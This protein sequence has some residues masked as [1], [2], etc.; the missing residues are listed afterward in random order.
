MPEINV[1]HDDYDNIFQLQEQSDWS[2]GPDTIIGG[3]GSDTVSYAAFTAGIRIDLSGDR[4]AYLVADDTETTNTDGIE[5]ITGGE[6]NDEITGDAE[7]NVLAGGPGNDT[8]TGKEGQDRYV[9]TSSWGEDIVVEDDSG[10]WNKFDAGFVDTLDFTGV[11]EALT[12]TVQDG[13][14]INATD[15]THTVEGG[16]GFIERIAG[17]KTSDTYTQIDMEITA[18]DKETMLGTDTTDG[19]LDYLQDWAA[20]LGG[21]VDEF[22]DTTLFGAI[23]AEGWLAPLLFD[24]METLIREISVYLDD[25]NAPWSTGD[26]SDNGDGTVDNMF[27]VEGITVSPTTYQKEFRATL[28]LG[29]LSLTKTIDL[30]EEISNVLGE[31]A[32][33]ATTA[34][35]DLTTDA[36]FDFSFGLEDDGDFYLADPALSLLNLTAG[37]TDINLG[38]DLGILGAGVSGGTL[39]YNFGVGFETTGHFVLTEDSDETFNYDDMS[40]QIVSSGDFIIDLPLSIDLAGLDF[41]LPSLE[42]GFVFGD[43]LFGGLTLDGLTT[44][45]MAYLNLS[46]VN[47]DVEDLF[48]IKKISLDD[49]VNVLNQT[50]DNIFDPDGLWF[51]AIPGVEL[52]L[53]DLTGGIGSSIVNAVDSLANLSLNEIE[54]YLDQQIAIPG[55]PAELGPDETG[56]YLNPD[57]SLA[58]NDGELFFGFT[59]DAGFN[60]E[61]DFGFDLD[62]FAGSAGGFFGAGGL[63]TVTGG[64]TLF[65]EVFAILEMGMGIDLTVDLVNPDDSLE[66]YITDSSGIEAGISLIGNDLNFVAAINTGLDIAP[67][68]GLHIKDGAAAAGAS[69]GIRLPEGDEEGHLPVDAVLDVTMAARGEFA[70]ALP[71]FLTASVTGTAEAHLGAAMAITGI[72]FLEAGTDLHY[73]QEISWSSDRPVGEKLIIGD[74]FVSLAGVYLEMGAFMTNL[75]GPV[76]DQV[77]KITQPMQPIA[78]LWNGPLPVIGDLGGPETVGD[79]VELVAGATDPRIDKMAKFFDAIVTIVEVV[80][81]FAGIDPNGRIFFGDFIL[82]SPGEK[83]DNEPGYDTTTPDRAG[84]ANYNPM[85]S[86]SGV[87]G[88]SKSFYSKNIKKE[89]GQLEF[90]IITDPTQIF[91][92]LT[93]RSADL[94]RYELP[95]T[96]ISIEYGASF[97]IFSG[98]NAVIGGS[99]E[100]GFQLGF[101]YDSSGL[102]QYITELKTNDYNLLVVDPTVVFDGFFLNDHVGAENNQA[103]AAIPASDGNVDYPEAWLQARLE[104]GLALGIGGLVEAG[105][106]G[107]FTGTVMFDLAEPHLDDFAPTH[108]MTE[109]VVEKDGKVTFRELEERFNNYSACCGP[110]CMIETSGTLAA[111]LSAFLWVGVKIFGA[112]ITLF[113][114]SF[115]LFEITLASFNHTCE[116]K[117]APDPASL[118]AEP[119]AI[120][121][122]EGDGPFPTNGNGGTLVLHMGSEA[123]K[124]GSNGSDDTDPNRDTSFIVE[125]V[126]EEDDLGNVIEENGFVRVTYNDAFMEEFPREDVGRIMAVGGSGNDKIVIKKP[127]DEGVDFAPEVAFIGGGGDDYTW[128]QTA[129]IAVLEGGDGD[130]VLIGGSDDDMIIGGDGND[131]IDGGGGNDILLGGGA[132]QIQGGF[133]NDYLYGDGVRFDEGSGALIVAPALTGNAATAAAEQG[134]DKLVG[135]GGDDV[136]IGFGGSD[137]LIG[138]GMTTKKAAR[139]GGVEGVDY[140]IVALPT[141]DPNIDSER[142]ETFGNDYLFGG[143]GDDRLTGYAGNDFLHGEDGDDSLNAGRGDDVVGV[144]QYQQSDFSGEL[145]AVWT[146]YLAAVNGEIDEDGPDTIRWTSG[147]GADQ[148][149]AGEDDDLLELTGAG[150]GDEW[151]FEPGASQLDVRMT[152]DGLQTNL[153]SVEKVVLNAGAGADTVTI[154]DIRTTTVDEFDIRLGGVTETLGT[155]NLLEAENRSVII[156]PNGSAEVVVEEAATDEEIKQAMIDYYG[157][158]EADDIT[159]NDDDTITVLGKGD[160]IVARPQQPAGPVRVFT[161]DAAAD[162]VVLLGSDATRDAFTINSIAS[163]LE[164]EKGNPIEQHSWRVSQDA[165]IMLFTIRQAG[166]AN[167]DELIIRTGDR[168]DLIDASGVSGPGADTMALTA[169]T[170]DG[171][172]ELRGTAFDDTLRGGSGDDLYTGGAGVD[173]FED[174]AGRNVLEEQRN[175]DFELTDGYLIVG[176]FSENQNSPFA[177]DFL[178]AS[179]EAYEPYPDQTRWIEVEGTNYYGWSNE[180]EFETLDNVRFV[181]FRLS[182]EDQYFSTADMWTHRQDIFYIHHFNAEA[183]L[184]GEGEAD[185][186]VIE[187]ATSLEA[188]ITEQD[189]GGVGHG[190]VPGSTIGNDT[191]VVIGTENEDEFGFNADS[192]NANP[193]DGEVTFGNAKLEYNGPEHLLVHGLGGDDNFIMDDNGVALLIFGGAGED[194]FQ[195]GQVLEEAFTDDI[196]AILYAAEMSSGVSLVSYFYGGTGNDYMEVN[197]NL[198]E[199]FLYGEDDNDRFVIN[200]HLEVDKTANN[201]GGVGNNQI[202]YVQNATVNING[203]EGIDTVVINGTPIDDTFIVAVVDGKQV[204]YGAGLQVGEMTDV[205]LLEVNGAAGNDSIYVFGTVDGMDLVINGGFGDDTIYAGGNSASVYV[206]PP[207]YTY[208]PPSYIVDPEPFQD[209]WLLEE[210]NPWPYLTSISIP[211]YEYSYHNPNIFLWPYEFGTRWHSGSNAWY[212]DWIDRY[213]GVPVSRVDTLITNSKSSMEAEFLSRRAPKQYQQYM[214]DYINDGSPEGTIHIDFD[215]WYSYYF[216]QIWSIG[217]G[218]RQL[219][220]AI[221]TVFGRGGYSSFGNTAWVWVDPAPYMQPIPNIVDPAPYVVVPEPVTVDPA[222]FLFT[223]GPSHTLSAFGGSFVVDGGEGEND[224]IVINS[225]DDTGDGWIGLTG[226]GPVNVD[227]LQGL[228]Y[229]DAD[230]NV[231]SITEGGDYTV[232]NGILTFTPDVKESTVGRVT[233]T[234]DGVLNKEGNPKEFIKFFR[235][236][237]RTILTGRNMQDGVSIEFGNA[238]ILNIE[239]SD[240]DDVFTV[241]STPAGSTT[242]VNA[243]DGNDTLHIESTGGI[244][245]IEG[246]GG[247]DAIFT[248]FNGTNPADAA[249]GSLVNISDRLIIRSGEGSDS[250][251]TSDAGRNEA[252]II[253]G[254][255]ETVEYIETV[256]DTTSKKDTPVAA[257]DSYGAMAGLE[258]QSLDVRS[259]FAYQFVKPGS[260]AEDYNEFI[261]NKLDQLSYKLYIKQGDQWIELNDNDGL[262]L[263][264]DNNKSWLIS[265]VPLFDVFD[266]GSNT[267]KVEATLAAQTESY[268]FDLYIARTGGM[269]G[270]SLGTIDVTG[271]AAFDV[272][273][274]GNVPRYRLYQKVGVSWVELDETSGISADKFE[275]LITGT[276]L[277]SDVGENLY[278]LEMYWRDGTDKSVDYAFG[279]DIRTA[280]VQTGEEMTPIDLRSAFGDSLDDWNEITYHLEGLPVGSGLKV[281]DGSTKASNKGLIIGNPTPMDVTGTLGRTIKLVA[282]SDTN[283]REERSFTLIVEEDT[284]MI[285]YKIGEIDL[286]TAVEND[287]GSLDG[288]SYA[289]SG[290]DGS[291]LT[292]N[293]QSGI[294]SGMPT[295]SG[296]YAIAVTAQKGAQIQTYNFSIDVEPLTSYVDNRI[297]AVDLKELF[298]GE[299]A[300][301]KNVIYTADG[302]NGTG[303]ILDPDTWRIVG[304]PKQVGIQNWTI[305]ATDVEKTLEK[306]LV[307][308]VEADLPDEPVDPIAVPRT[309][310]AILRQAR[311]TSFDSSTHISYAGGAFALN[312]SEATVNQNDVVAV[313]NNDYRLRTI[314][315]QTTTEQTRNTLIQTGVPGELIEY[316]GIENLTIETGQHQD[317][318]DIISTLLGL[319]INLFTHSGADEINIKTTEI[320]I[321][322]NAGDSNDIVNIGSR[323]PESNGTV[324]QIN[325]LVTVDGGGGSDMLN[326]DETGESGN[327]TGSLTSQT[328]TG[329]GMAEGVRYQAFAT[330]NIELGSG[331]DTF[332]VVST[333]SGTSNIYGNSNSD[334]IYVHST[335]GTTLI[336]GGG[337]SDQIEVGNTANLLNDIS[338]TLIISGTGGNDIVI[339]NDSGESQP[340]S[341]ILSGHIL[342]GFGIGNEINVN[343][344]E[345]LNILLGSNNDVLTVQNTYPGETDI[346]TGSGNDEIVIN[347][348]GGPTTIKGGSGN[349]Q[350]TTN[351]LGPVTSQ[352]IGSVLDTLTLD[353]QTGSDNYVINLSGSS[354]YEINIEDNGG[355]T[356]E[357]TM[358]LNATNQDDTLLFRE[359]FVALLNDNQGDDQA[360]DAVERINYD[361]QESDANVN[362]GIETLIVN[363]LGGDDYL[364][365]DDNSAVTELYGGGNDWFQIGQLFETPRDANAGVEPRDQYKENDLI[366][367]TTDGQ[368]SQWL[369]NGIS[370]E[371]TINGGSDDDIFSVYHNI[372]ELNLSG[373]DGDDR[374]VVRSFVLKDTSNTDSQQQMV[375]IKAGSGDNTIAYAAKAPV[376]ISGGSGFDSI[377]VTGTFEAD[378][379]VITAN[380]IYGAGRI[381]RYAGVEQIEVDGLE[382][383]DS[384]YVRSTRENLVTQVIGGLGNDTIAVLGEIDNPIDIGLVSGAELA[385]SNL[386][387]ITIVNE[388]FAA[389][390]AYEDVL[391]ELAGPLVV[392]GGIGQLGSFVPDTP[393]MLL[394]EKDGDKQGGIII[395]ETPEIGNDTESVDT[396]LVNNDD[397]ENDDNGLLSETQLSGLGLPEDL[398]LGLEDGREFTFDGGISYTE[399]EEMEIDLGGGNDQFRINSTFTGNTLINVGGGSDLIDIQTIAGSTTVNTGSE[400]DQIFVGQDNT[401]SRDLDGISAGLTF[402]LGSGE[403]TLSVINIADTNDHT[404]DITSNTLSW[405][406]IAVEGIT[407]SNAEL[408]NIDLGTG[409]NVFNILST[410]SGNTNISSLSGSETFNVQTVSGETVITSGSGQDVFNIGTL[411]PA[412]G[413]TLDLIGAALAVDA[414]SDADIINLDDSGDE[415]DNAGTLI[416][417]SLTGFDMAGKIDYANFEMLNF[418]SGSG[419]DTLTIESTHTGETHVE[420][421]L[422]DDEVLVGAS[423]GLLDPITGLLTVTDSEG[424]DRITM[425]DAGDTDFNFGDLTANTLSGLGLADVIQYSGYETT[426]LL[427][428]TNNDTLN[429]TSIHEGTTRIETG[430]GIDD[431]HVGNLMPEAGGTLN[432]IMGL[433]Q[434]IGGEDG[435][436]L[437]IDH[438][439]EATPQAARLTEDRLTGL[440]LP[441]AIEYEKLSQLH[442]G[443]GAGDDTFNVQGTSAHT[444]LR[445]NDGNDRLFISSLADYGT[446]DPPPA[447]LTGDLNAINGPLELN[448]GKGSHR[449]MVSDS[450]AITGDA[451]A[452]MTRETPTFMTES[453][454]VL[455]GLSSGMIGYITDA[456]EGDFA[457]G[458]HVWLSQGDDELAINATHRREGVHTITTVRTNSGNDAINIAIDENLDDTL[459][460]HG[461]TGDDLLDGS[462]ST[463]RLF[464]SGEEGKDTLLGGT[465]DD[466]LFGDFGSIEGDYRNP[467]AA[468][469]DDDES[470]DDD[471]IIAG[472][473]ND[474]IFGGKGNDTLHGDEGLDVILGDHGRYEITPEIGQAITS[475]ESVHAG[476]DI[477]YGGVGDDFILGQAGEDQIFGGGGQ[478]DLIGGHN[479][480]GGTDGSDIIEGGGDSDVIVADNGDIARFLENEQWILYPAPFADVQRSVELYYGDPGS[481]GDDIVLGGSGD[482]HIFGQNG[483]DH[484]SGDDGD[485][486][487][488]GGPGSNLLFGGAGQDMLIGQEGIIYR[489]YEPDGSPRLNDDGSWHR[490]VM[491][492]KSAILTDIIDISQRLDLSSELIAEKIY[493]ADMIIAAG[494][495]DP[496]GSAILQNNTWQTRLLLINLTPVGNHTLEGGPGNDVLFGYL[497]DDMLSGGGDNDQIYGDEASNVV[498]FDTEIP[499]IMNTLRI[500]NTSEQLSGDISLDENGALIAEPMSLKTSHLDVI[501]P[502][503]FDTPFGAVMPDAIHDMI[504]Q[505]NINELAMSDGSRLRGMFSFIPAIAGH[506]DGLPGN[507]MIDG[508]DGDDMI[509]ADQAL[510]HTELAGELKEIDKARDTLWQSLQT[511]LYLAESVMNEYVQYQDPD[512]DH[513]LTVGNDTI[514]AGSGNDM[515]FGDNGLIV[516]S[517][518]SNLPEID[519]RYINQAARLHQ[520]LL[521]MN[522]LA[523]DTEAALFQTHHQLIETMIGQV[524]SDNL[525]RSRIHPQDQADPNLHDLSLNNDTIIS[526]S[527]N[528]MVVGDDGTIVSTYIDNRPVAAGA[529]EAVDPEIVKSTEV[530]LAIQAAQETKQLYA[531]LKALNLNKLAHRNWQLDDL[532][533]N[534]P[535]DLSIHNNIIDDEAGSDVIFG[536]IAVAAVP[537][538]QTAAGDER[539]ARLIEKDIDVLLKD[540]SHYM[541][542][543]YQLQSSQTRSRWHHD[544]YSD[545]GGPKTQFKLHAG[546]DQITTADGLDYILGDSASLSAAVFKES[547]ETPYATSRPLSLKIANLR[548]DLLVHQNGMDYNRHEAQINTDTI[549]AGGSPVVYGQWG[550]DILNVDSE[551]GV[552]YGGSGRDEITSNAATIRNGGSDLPDA[553]T[554]Q[555]AGEQFLTTSDPFRSFLLDLTESEDTTQPELTFLPSLGSLVE[556]Q[557]LAAASQTPLDQTDILV[558]VDASG[559]QAYEELLPHDTFQSI[560]NCQPPSLSTNPPKAMP[561][562]ALSSL[563]I[564]TRI[565]S[566]S[567]A[568]TAI[569]TGCKSAIRP[570]TAGSWTPRSN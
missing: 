270:R 394:N 42:M 166:R 14:V 545:R 525:K 330:V 507:D 64:G 148:I 236:G 293:D 187:L 552:V 360:A 406:D 57:F 414:G 511:V 363:A 291:G 390:P 387:N 323:S 244:T 176:V 513:L 481:F 154:D 392:K 127:R 36:V 521:D 220:N 364:A 337:G 52:S 297:K 31:L 204:I 408:L 252:G 37:A 388:R 483:D 541:I 278:K 464:L 519:I 241:N 319:E 455:A 532:P 246:G 480:S 422:G 462:L 289:I 88:G 557:D 451:S 165:G 436:Q 440:G 168:G 567:P 485:D 121:A 373:E 257:V 325:A 198:A 133:G 381:N 473:A 258:I 8:L 338:G 409:S 72:D 452:E 25:A 393:I 250:V 67:T 196:P 281:D 313:D 98:L 19:G 90:P 77:K 74:P 152:L 245:V 332:T 217:G 489:A 69:F 94:F 309:E 89:P 416:S 543:Q 206:D 562:T 113:D 352:S 97:P 305:Q 61:K 537:V 155:V 170:G 40:S 157:D 62:D 318:F 295:G 284:E 329:L 201:F 512:D 529:V 404:G 457:A 180:A 44:E 34:T 311:N 444:K 226:K 218:E 296:A 30:G 249:G 51:E 118:I 120:V 439:G 367:V 239:L 260:P 548:E 228:P 105:V 396:L 430:A 41:N 447:E 48:N 141:E 460:V 333:H 2:G 227:L 402:D 75:V 534:Y 150:D 523:A 169:E 114:E 266:F 110:L 137:V 60:G 209:G 143:D 385:D 361:Y 500:F 301:S 242:V 151:R 429:I 342:T 240:H 138:D 5:N 386:D 431:V 539:E 469:T 312:Y 161:A 290:L 488:I 139:D 322:L 224:R 344:I 556:L 267:L 179:P 421:G 171:G 433:L 432:G 108:P 306:T 415:K 516:Q 101:G 147:D 410:H 454:I 159:I 369:T 128:V 99:V 524:E 456:V 540:L 378:S 327:D 100:V 274:N 475:L 193:S 368:N 28:D 223:A 80:N 146:H 86:S 156:D 248:G 326:I 20:A 109:V 126:D 514:N 283:E 275:G 35:A 533:W 559:G 175:A 563:I 188:I 472:A 538:V 468:H 505:E 12:I 504:V 254:A 43:D 213:F 53:D 531:H 177:E 288:V 233:Y 314:T 65:V 144:H 553:Y 292:F 508:G 427:L 70:L 208:Q 132:D 354:E 461:E 299:F 334:T 247:D 131:F 304:I 476:D 407:Y 264:S 377:L 16:G 479:H 497:G 510:V 140:V 321:N 375:A 272:N 542:E 561:P 273:L 490:D 199:V 21:S 535:Y 551:D 81:E 287:L 370:F 471:T 33:V 130:D 570:R 229:D 506:R 7:N 397:S 202:T 26:G 353:G 350:F 106:L 347:Q 178:D 261:E 355:D 465:N 277:P 160:E 495:Y 231:E 59:F 453:E 167:G 164:D 357:D 243:A 122:A 55:L 493:N 343:G 251:H 356:S 549:T 298:K 91:N 182:G 123:I 491:L 467:T 366:E 501:T 320:P 215:A 335:A 345:L 197:H 29:T 331:Q 482:D 172:D 400:N 207:A 498:S 477:L 459:I 496:A 134:N 255:L 423:G 195:I 115:K 437:N 263:L 434:V 102:Q 282:I 9:F 555:A 317:Q 163:L 153:V 13:G 96:S 183:A 315:D 380:A 268:E 265:G 192:F 376:N 47:F 565:T 286:R 503:I 235:F 358:E 276:P 302:L 374:F 162:Q 470:G 142:A 145:A 124:R 339:L 1:T 446:D 324:D 279:I 84:D 341:G 18:A 303:F 92:L 78:D 307:M 487:I 190:N 191:I 502:Y 63:F 83:L 520:Y 442:I 219:V 23:G 117:P 509:F 547:L 186:Y 348:F 484:L 189:S 389:F 384:I 448:T 499:H 492:Q 351:Q 399:L 458:I 412:T 435:D 300:D 395:P 82:V 398:M 262:H 210:Y 515:I 463:H 173:V 259:V 232:S 211:F 58:Y 271:A 413:G 32:N 372:A 136:L 212:S 379:F 466:I 382:G 316:N 411:A 518:I 550:A 294:I 45:I 174:M 24:K 527:G 95:S 530:S 119:P 79:L 200:A 528:D 68:I 222:P 486:E 238:S 554:S 280:N 71:L 10:P 417:E 4:K 526:G 546:N 103:P 111:D 478:D 391:T 214:T 216:N 49:I 27:E 22:F 129:G 285:G 346:Q 426:M 39:G 340:D 474:I 73:V 418:T 203:G 253:N 569:T 11:A 6:G 449:L 419:S 17:L 225:Q 359:Y 85:N 405:T 365:L 371:T 158:I 443:V 221:D 234:F 125:V 112:K 116:P 428:G 56:A 76:I 362:I 104:A 558:S 185:R 445:L 184:D 560:W 568:S 149:D 54:M 15:G 564:R 107:G 517:F 230:L 308:N 438:S 494:L 237:E 383:D 425:N 403:D 66:P 135:G 50:V 544:F 424:K 93:G 256:T 38:F 336:N 87:D 328:I 566:S 522:R 194:S 269:I 450:Q 310:Y 420:T 349:D 46:T 205:E 401:G 536:N 181:T 3:D 441:E